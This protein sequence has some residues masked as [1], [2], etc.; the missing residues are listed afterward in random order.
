MA[1]VNTHTRIIRLLLL[2]MT[3]VVIKDVFSQ[4]NNPCGKSWSQWTTVWSGPNGQVDYQLEFPSKSCGCGW[5][6]VRIRHTLPY[7]A[8]VSIWLEGKDCDGKSMTSSFDAETMGGE[9][10]SDQ[11]DWHSFK[12]VS[13]VAK[14]QIEYEDGDKRVKIVTTRSGTTRYING[15]SEKA[16]NQQQQQKQKPATSSAPA[17]KSSNVNSNSSS[18]NSSRTNPS[19]TTAT[20]SQRQA[21][22]LEQQRLQREDAYR[23]QQEAER[24]Q[25]E[26]AIRQNELRYQAQL[27]EITRKSEARAQRDAAIMDGFAGIVS[28]FQKNKTDRDLREDAGKRSSKLSEYEKKLAE[29]GYELIDC[30]HCDLDGFDRCGQCKSKGSIKC[31]SCNGEAGKRCSS[32][33]GTGKKGYGPYQVACFSCSGTGERKCLPCANEGSNICFLCR[34]RGEVQCGHCA[35]TGKMLER[36]STPVASTYTSASPAP[37]DYAPVAK[38]EVP[39]PVIARA[40]EGSNFLAKNKLKPGVKTTASGLQYQVLRVGKGKLPKMGDTLTYHTKMFDIKGRLLFDSYSSI[41]PAVSALEKN[42]NDLFNANLEAFP[43]MS[44]GSKYKFF[45]PSHLAFKELDVELS[46]GKF[47]PGG[48]ALIVEYE[49]LGVK[50]PVKEILQEEKRIDSM[51]YTPINPQLVKSYNKVKE[52]SLFGLTITRCYEENKRLD[53]KIETSI[54][55]REGDGYYP[56]DSYGSDIVHSSQNTG[57]IY[58]IF[59]IASPS[60]YKNIV[61]ELEARAKSMGLKVIKVKQVK[62]KNEKPRKRLNGEDFWNKF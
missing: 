29:G 27:Q 36:I 48:S 42:P 30:R 61:S 2:L 23:R 20:A 54:L 24:R 3:M 52:D 40:E 22:S 59:Y 39:S 55:Y 62:Y 57:S 16:Y 46:E 47:L 28:I 35:G 5:K 15:M 4:N 45:I 18:I 58:D 21:Q 44:V 32:C 53:V 25:R 10:S 26:E 38:E 49:L 31:S 9:I 19:S 51:L 37:S 11:G 41:Q 33:N 34:G 43:M 13:G 14:V 6:F 56:T 1:L 8:F 17:Y 60:S 12:S 7:R 50:R